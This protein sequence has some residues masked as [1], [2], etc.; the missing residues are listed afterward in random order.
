MFKKVCLNPYYNGNG[1][2]KKVQ[3][4]YDNRL[5]GF[6]LIIQAWRANRK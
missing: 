3:P 4:N 2:L 6:Y 1:D 5:H